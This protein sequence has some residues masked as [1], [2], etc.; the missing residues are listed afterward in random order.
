MQGQALRE[1]TTINLLQQRWQALWT[2]HRGSGERLVPKEPFITSSR[3]ELQLHVTVTR[4][5]YVVINIFKLHFLLTLQ[6]LY[7]TL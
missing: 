5:M 2:C 7:E 3:V 1:I 6:Q 4:C